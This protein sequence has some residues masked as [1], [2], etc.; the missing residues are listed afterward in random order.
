M[1]YR[2]RYG[3]MRRET[4]L[5]SLKQKKLKVAMPWIRVD[6]PKYHSRIIK[7]ARGN[8]QYHVGFSIKAEVF[9]ERGTSRWRYVVGYRNHSA[10]ASYRGYCY[11][12]ERA[13]EKADELLAKHNVR[14]LDQKALA[15]IKLFT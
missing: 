12:K 8:Y 6:N 10:L 7:Y 4:W 14:P 1:S 5:L 9:R 2:R 3:T 13:F 15:R 11:S